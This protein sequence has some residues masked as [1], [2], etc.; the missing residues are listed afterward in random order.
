MHIN[1]KSLFSDCLNL[2]NSNILQESA[3]RENLWRIRREPEENLNRIRWKLID[4]SSFVK[5]AYLAAAYTYTIRLT[6]LTANAI[7][8][9]DDSRMVKC[10]L[11]SQLI[12]SSWRVFMNGARVL[13]RL[14][15]ITRNVTLFRRMLVREASWKLE[16]AAAKELAKKMPFLYKKY[17]KECWKI[18]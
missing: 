16:L 10:F 14:R 9:P 12:H 2:M 3:S 11:L 18:F 13:F 15:F 5:D 4:K 8:E 1:W 7:L 6:F 17:S